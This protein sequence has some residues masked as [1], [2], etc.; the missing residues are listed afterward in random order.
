MFQQQSYCPTCP[1][2][3]PPVLLPPPPPTYAPAP[4]YSAPAAAPAA[5]PAANPKAL[6]GFT[7]YTTK[8]GNPAIKQSIKTP[9]GSHETR[10]VAPNGF[11]VEFAAG[12]PWIVAK[13]ATVYLQP[14]GLA[15]I[16][17]PQGEATQGGK[18]AAN[19]GL[20]PEFF[21]GAKHRETSIETNDQA[22]ARVGLGLESSPAMSAPSEA[23]LAFGVAAIVLALGILG[24]AIVHKTRT[25]RA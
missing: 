5:K 20:G 13:E 18:L 14:D 6:G 21:K 11:E 2:Y 22:L 25:K 1:G 17:I 12:H 9:T 23:G 10:I 7:A 19:Y 8:E 24:A 4:I 3:A 16:A 15:G